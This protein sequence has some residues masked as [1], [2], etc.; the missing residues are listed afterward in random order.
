MTSRKKTLGL[1]LST[2]RKAPG[3]R[4]LEE[5]NVFSKIECDWHGL[6]AAKSTD[7][8]FATIEVS[9]DL[10]NEQLIL[11]NTPA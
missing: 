2:G 10:T 4:S 11:T 6:S 7:V 5:T 9:I 8:Q 1:L 3:E